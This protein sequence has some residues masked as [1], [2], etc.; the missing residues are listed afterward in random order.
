M[1]FKPLKNDVYDCVNSVPRSC[2]RKTN[3]PVWFLRVRLFQD[4][5]FKS[6]RENAHQREAPHVSPVPE[7]L[8]HCDAPAEPRQHPHRWRHEDAASWASGLRERESGSFDVM[9]VD[10]GFVSFSSI[11]VKN[12]ERHSGSCHLSLGWEGGSLMVLRAT[13]SFLKRFETARN[14]HVTNSPENVWL[15]LKRTRSVLFTGTRPYKCGDCDMAFVTSGELVRHRRYKHTH[16]KPFKC[17]MCK[18]ASVEVSSLS[19]VKLPGVL[20]SSCCK[21][22]MLNKPNCRTSYKKGFIKDIIH[23]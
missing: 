15:N 21:K 10:V 23:T 8:P 19:H 6:S 12:I 14:L 3:L 2:R 5:E 20:L 1:D 11:S 7:G 9:V 16:E 4:F 22:V 17:S 18:Y 13:S